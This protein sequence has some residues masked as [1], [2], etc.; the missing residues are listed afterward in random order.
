MATWVILMLVPIIGISALVVGLLLKQMSNKTIHPSELSSQSR[1][2]LRNL[3]GAVERLEKLVDQYPN[4]PAIKVIGQEALQTAYQLRSEG[5]KL[6]LARDQ[7][8]ELRMAGDERAS[9]VVDQIDLKIDGAAEAINELTIRF[10]DHASD[11]PVNY[12]DSQLSEL[13]GRLQNLTHSF[14]EVQETIQNKT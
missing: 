8:L 6:G 11:S 13:V 3:R 12:D 7:M 4:D 14:D 1:S 5:Q 2:K 9:K 10:A